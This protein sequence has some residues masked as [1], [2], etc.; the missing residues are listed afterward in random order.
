MPGGAAAAPAR[1]KLDAAQLVA[2][3]QDDAV[4]ALDD[5][6]AATGAAAWRTLRGKS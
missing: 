5:Q 4:G 2:A 1:P 6:V 3:L